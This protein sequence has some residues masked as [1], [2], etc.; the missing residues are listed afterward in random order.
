MDIIKEKF[1][2]LKNLSNKKKKEDNQ[3]NCIYAC[4]LRIDVR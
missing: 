1:F 4:D 2:C 3:T